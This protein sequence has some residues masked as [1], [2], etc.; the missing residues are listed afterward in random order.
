V[1]QDHKMQLHGGDVTIWEDSEN[2]F[3]YIDHKS[4]VGMQFSPDER[5]ALYLWLRYPWLGTTEAEQA[6]IAT[7]ERARPHAQ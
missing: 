7:N 4:G 6:L 2:G 3:M 1:A 5:N